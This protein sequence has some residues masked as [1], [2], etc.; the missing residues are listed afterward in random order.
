MSRSIFARLSQALGQTQ[1]ES[2]VKHRRA[3]A[4]RFPGFERLEGR[5]LMATIN[6]SA[7]INSV[8]AGSNFNYTIT[9][10][11]EA[12]STSPVGTFWYAWTAVPFDDFLAT[13][14][15]SVAS[16]SG[17]HDVITNVG[18][19]DGF[20][21]EYIAN[22]PA[23][24][25]Q[26]GSSLNFQ[27]TSADTPASVNGN[28]VFYPNIPVGTS[29]VYPAGP[30][31]DAGHLFVVTSATTPP[32]NNPPTIIGEQVV[33]VTL[34]H[35][36][37]GKPI[38]MPKLSFVFEFSTAMDP[39][40]VNNTNNYQLD[41]VSTKKIK[42]RVQTVLHSIGIQSAT[43]NASTNSVT[44]VTS[45]TSTKF[46]K[47]GRLTVIGSPV[48]IESAAGAF[49]AENAVFMISPKARSLAP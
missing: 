33:P 36:K 13:N 49:L 28:S 34:K 25:V 21:I 30:F 29:I 11:N 5:A 22:S 20:A 16:P 43:Y 42:K 6:V 1:A 35:N 27:F 46:P 18:S 19:R 26:P 9:L 44:L 23:S 39:A 48:G 15:I 4:H 8:S 40:S 7:V 37:H 3:R 32:P 2:R 38:G 31:S 24:Y 12:S 10:T 47:G 17:W 41:S 14:P 45:A